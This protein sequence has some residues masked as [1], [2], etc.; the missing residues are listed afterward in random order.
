M[1]PG[2]CETVKCEPVL[3]ARGRGRGWSGSECEKKAQML[4][5]TSFDF[6]SLIFCSL[7]PRNKWLEIS[8]SLHFR[9]PL[10]FSLFIKTEWIEPLTP[11]PPRQ[12]NLRNST[13]LS[14]SKTPRI[15]M[16]TTMIMFGLYYTLSRRRENPISV[17][18][19]IFNPIPS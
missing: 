2:Y 1:E 18:S 13:P 15:M 7:S 9:L 8:L 14:S 4:S 10:S 16:M 19:V 17:V 5:L 3:V 12:Q 11:P 6:S